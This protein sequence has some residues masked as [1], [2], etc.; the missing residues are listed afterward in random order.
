[1]LKWTTT[2]PTRPGFY[3]ISHVGSKD[4]VLL[5]E[6]VM[7]AADTP[8]WEE[9][10]QC[11]PLPTTEYAMGHLYYGPLTPPKAPK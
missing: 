2:R 6:L 9:S 4:C 3:W 8:A 7:I 5:Q 10:D 1:M 11:D